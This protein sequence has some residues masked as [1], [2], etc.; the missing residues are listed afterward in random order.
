MLPCS[1]CGSRRGVA[2]IALS[3]SRSP[4]GEVAASLL[5]LDADCI[6]PAGAPP[7][8][9]LLPEPAKRFSTRLQVLVKASMIDEGFARIF[10]SGGVVGGVEPWLHVADG[11]GG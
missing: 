8:I 6:G 9:R 11:I 2:R 4:A 1:R 3:T 7:A 5:K 10:E